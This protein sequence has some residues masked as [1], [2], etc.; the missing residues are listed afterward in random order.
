MVTSAGLMALPR[1]DRELPPRQAAAEGTAG[2]TGASRTWTQWWWIAVAVV[3]AGGLAI[4]VAS[5][6][7]LPGR[8]TEGGDALYYHDAA[9]LLVHGL[10]GIDP[11]AY[12]TL[13][14]HPHIP[15]ANFPPLFSGVLALASL[16][17]AKSVVA[18]RIWSCVIG[19]AAIPLGAAFGRQLVGRRVGLIAA[20]LIA[21]YPNLWM[22][23]AL[24]L[25]ESLTPI[26]VLL[27]LMSTYRFWRRP[28]VG[29]ACLIG[30]SLGAAALGRDELALL[31][32]L[33]FVPVVLLARLSWR[34][35]L[36]MLAAGL[37]VA[38]VLVGPWVGWNLVRFQKPV[39][40]SDGYGITLATASCDETWNGPLAGYWSAV[41]ARRY[42]RGIHGDEAATGAALQ[43]RAETYI[44][45]HLGSLPRVE[46][47]KVGRGFGF[48]RP[49]QQITFDVWLE[50]R[51]VRWAHVGLWM[52][53][54]LAA[55]SVGGVV[56]LR[57]RRT[58]VF[59][60]L[61]VG[62]GVVVTMALTFG[63]TRYRTPFE[64]C[65]VVLAAV[66]LDAIAG[67]VTPRLRGHTPA[68]EPSA[69]GPQP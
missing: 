51:P 4:R 17:G 1:T 7:A 43:A 12:Y 50:K 46:A 36:A 56:I 58:L 40:I 16:V 29:N 32:V 22:T 3:T 65:L 20:V 19:A 15:S 35:R 57:R 23:N 14:G 42:D 18:H 11:I 52:Y 63:D 44:K 10:I 59:P 38:G 49:L 28:S 9:N 37:A 30:A 45:H 21:V 48:F 64:V 2:K 31:V 66:A 47:E 41:C 68:G 26:L 69:N 5:V 67:W 24:A 62:A 39:F 8:Q 13:P 6:F 53:Y 60:F 25:S 34:Q 61:A 27:V 55:L 33:I 54:G